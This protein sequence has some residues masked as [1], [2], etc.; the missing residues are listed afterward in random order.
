M[1]IEDNTDHRPEWTFRKDIQPGS[2]KP[3]PQ[4]AREFERLDPE[5]AAAG[6]PFQNMIDAKHPEND[7][8]VRCEI[9]FWDGEYAIPKDAAADYFG[10]ELKRHIKSVE[11]GREI[12]KEQRLDTFEKDMPYLTLE[13]F[14]TVGLIGRIDQYGIPHKDMSQRERKELNENR[15]LWFNRAQNATSDDQDRRGSWGEGKFTLEGSSEL[16]AQISWSIRSKEPEPRQV[17]MGQTTLRWHAIHDV[18][19]GYG[20]NTNYGECEPDVFGPFGFFSTSKLEDTGEGYAPLPVTD[21]LYIQRFRDTFRMTRVDE[22]GLSILIPHPKFT[23]PDAFARAI[24]SRWLISIFDGHMAFTIRHNGE[25]IHVINQE[26]LL[27]VIESLDW[28]LEI[29]W[30]GS[31]GEPNPAWRSKEC[32]KSFIHLLNWNRDPVGEY[33]FNADPT[34]NRQ[35]G[36]SWTSP[37][38]NQGEDTLDR[39]RDAFESGLPIRIT[40]HPIVA[41]QTGLINGEF[42]VL[43]QKVPSEL[44]GTY[45]ARDGMGIPF[46]KEEYDG[47]LAIVHCEDDHVGEVSLRNLLRDSEGPAHLTW[48]NNAP[49]VTRKGMKWWMGGAGVRYVTDS[50]KSLME[51]AKIPPEEEE[52]A[53]SLFSITIND[54]DSPTKKPPSTTAPPVAPPPNKQPDICRIP[55][56]GHNGAVRVRRNPDYG[57]SGKNI[58]IDLAYETAR[59]NSWSKYSS[60]DF[61]VEDIDF[62][63]EGA[64]LVMAVSKPSKKRGLVMTFNITNDNWKIDLTGFGQDR[65]IAVD[66][67]EVAV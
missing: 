62:D 11:D 28:E 1:P 35:A 24:I 64:V 43:L 10:P 39:F 31:K 40:A 34:G 45:F 57:M 18:T 14:G 54:Q 22:P 13:D 17:L 30:T 60:L 65:D 46:M 15:F 19:N 36:P 8:P 6:D 49:R 16:G 7:G 4:S 5:Q 56:K 42:T 52:H 41:T 58:E 33:C 20:R 61:D 21:E 66:V 3:N 67:S 51:L 2:K 47:I 12:A 23:D 63:C 37:F 25:I 32:W 53:V 50:V 26:T 29:A 59:G 27:E 44:T 48:A 55:S 38:S 9:G